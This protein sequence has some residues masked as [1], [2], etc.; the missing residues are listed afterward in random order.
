MGEEKTERSA[1]PR[2]SFLFVAANRVATISFNYTAAAAGKL[3]T[4]AAFN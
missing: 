1:F 2:L 3:V 4:A